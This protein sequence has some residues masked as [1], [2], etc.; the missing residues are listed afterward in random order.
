M[1]RGITA[2]GNIPADAVA[3]WDRTFAAATAT[4]EW[5]AE[6]AKNIGPIRFSPAPRSKRFSTKNA[7]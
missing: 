3:F 1:W 6:L 7:R 4:A 2:A 5:Q